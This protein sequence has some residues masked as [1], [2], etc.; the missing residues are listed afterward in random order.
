MGAQGT[1][2]TKSY[3]LRSYMAPKTA[4]EAV[5]WNVKLPEAVS[6]VVETSGLEEEE[7]GVS[8]RRA[9][10]SKAIRLT[11][12]GGKATAVEVGVVVGEEEE[13]AGSVITQ[14]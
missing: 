6:A 14:A 11:S 2:G 4:T 1:L 9:A 8:F 5:L 7:E 10:T 13:P 3:Q 12:S